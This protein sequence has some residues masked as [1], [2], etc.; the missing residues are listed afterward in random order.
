MIGRVIDYSASDGD[1]WRGSERAAVFSCFNYRAAITRERWVF[2]QCY[3]TECHVVG[4]TRL[5]SVTFYLVNARVNVQERITI[6]DD[7]YDRC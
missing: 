3:S 5:A 6:V 4:I 1:Y 2:V 7:Y